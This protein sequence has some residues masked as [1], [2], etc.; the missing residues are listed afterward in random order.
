MWIAPFSCL[1]IFRY[2][3]GSS[4]E[5]L[6][7]DNEFSFNIPSSYCLY[8]PNTGMNTFPWWVLFVF[9]NATLMQTSRNEIH[10]SS[11]SGAVEH[12]LF[13]IFFRKK[14]VDEAILM[15]ELVTC[16]DFLIFMINWLKLC[17]G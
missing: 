8:L 17:P 4:G 16:A 15:K 1:L 3:L 10:Q 14:I 12:K 5:L 11:N 9:G 2:I 6:T 13:G 7:C